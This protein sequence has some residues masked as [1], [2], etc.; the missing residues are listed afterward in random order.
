MTRKLY[1]TARPS[2]EGARRLAWLLL[3]RD[4]DA[5]RLLHERGVNDLRIERMLRGEILPGMQDGRA[6]F[7]ASHHA[8]AAWHWNH[9]PLGAWGDRPSDWPQFR[10]SLKAAA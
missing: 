7:F 3:D 6:I 10:A 2:N 4:A 1:L 9:A 8:I 5:R